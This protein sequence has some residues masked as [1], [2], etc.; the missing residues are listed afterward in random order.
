ME[1]K[2]TLEEGCKMQGPPAGAL[3]VKPGFNFVSKG[4]LP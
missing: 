1:S 2:P 3:A 4:L